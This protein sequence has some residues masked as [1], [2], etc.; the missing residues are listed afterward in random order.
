MTVTVT[1]PGPG[2]GKSFVSANLARAFADIGK[3]TLLIDGDT[4]RGQLHGIMDVDRK[5]GL[6]NVLQNGDTYSHAPPIRKTGHQGLYVLPS[7]SR[8]KEGPELLSSRRM[9]D[10]VLDLRSD[11]EVIIIDSPPLGAG[12]DPF[13]LGTLTGA[14]LVVLRTGETDRE[15]ADAKLDLMERLPVRILGAVL[16]GVPSGR[17]YRYYSY[18]AGY[19]SW[20]EEDIPEPPLLEK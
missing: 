19:E 5:P 6:V 13:V 14:M 10:L 12:V 11:F 3:K 20:N 15:L 9:R 16:N 18:T 17:G 8:V 2:D 1:S 4:R 7:G